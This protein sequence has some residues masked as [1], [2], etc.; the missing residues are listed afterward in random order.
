MTEPSDSRERLIAAAVRIYAKHGYLGATTRR[1]AEEAGLNEVTLF[2]LFGSKE[3]LVEEAIRAHTLRASPATLPGSPQAPEAELTEWCRAE[4][5]RLRSAR[6]LLRQCFA[7]ADTHPEHLQEASAAIIAAAHAVRR[8]VERLAAR[9]LV[10]APEHVD[11]AIAMLVSAVVADGLA[12]E[13]LPDVYPTP[14]DGAPA[15]YVR[16]FLATIGVAGT[17][18]RLAQAAE[19]E[20]RRRSGAS[21]PT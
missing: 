7:D 2:R 3:A 1:I 10:S 8:Y 4:T 21:R 5:V 18:V 15:A 12:R 9:G 13:Q 16:A 19:P 11:A 20:G 14:A 17:H 6:G